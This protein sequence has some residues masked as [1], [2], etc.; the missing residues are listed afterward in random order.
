[1]TVWS[2]LGGCVGQLG[3]PF[4]HSEMAAWFRHHPR[5]GDAALATRIAAPDA[6]ARSHRLAC[7]L[8]CCEAAIT[9]CLPAPLSYRN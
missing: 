5:I 7:A 2:M 3:E 4:R 8:R 9:A 1:M 6:G